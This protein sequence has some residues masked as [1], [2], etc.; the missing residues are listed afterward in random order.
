MKGA[1]AWVNME[2]NKPSAMSEAD[3]DIYLEKKR[4]SKLKI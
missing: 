4:M 2:N 3:W 1:E